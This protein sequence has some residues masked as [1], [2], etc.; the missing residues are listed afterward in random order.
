VH[1]IS[2][3]LTRKELIDPALEKAYWF[4][5]D[6][7][8]IKTEIPVDG[9]DASPFNGITDYSLYRPNGEVIGIVEAKRSTFDPKI[10][11]QQATH[12]VTEIAKHQS[13]HLLRF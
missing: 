6:R 8:L 1:R 10:A 2:E 9:Y 11:D 4:L 3:K 13:F 7:S 5:R 12:Y